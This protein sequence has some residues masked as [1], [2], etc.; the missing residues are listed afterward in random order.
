LFGIPPVLILILVAMGLK[1]IAGE[2][3]T[4]IWYDN[5]TYKNDGWFDDF[6]ELGRVIFW[7]AFLGVFLYIFFLITPRVSCTYEES[8]PI[9]QTVSKT[10]KHSTAKAHKKRNSAKKARHHLG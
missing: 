8:T 9:V 4:D 2:D 6:F 10:G 5:F 1:A 7:A 3:W